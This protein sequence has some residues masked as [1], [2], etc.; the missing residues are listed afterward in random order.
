MKIRI[1]T[2]SVDWSYKRELKRWGFKI[3]RDWRWSVY[4]ITIPLNITL[5]R[6][7]FGYFI[8]TKT[9]RS[10]GHITGNPFE[11]D[12]ALLTFVP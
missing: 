6:C 10:L 3:K 12:G 9:G 2:Y 5:E 1:K 7:F 8:V 4:V 11:M